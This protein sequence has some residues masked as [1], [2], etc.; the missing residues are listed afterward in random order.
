MGQVL[1]P[2]ILFRIDRDPDIIRRQTACRKGLQVVDLFRDGL[3]SLNG[4]S[5]IVIA[6]EQ[7]DS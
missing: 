7:A 3:E 2:D 4:G 1:L 5:G 6:Q